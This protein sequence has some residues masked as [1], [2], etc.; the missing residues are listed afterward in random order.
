MGSTHEHLFTQMVILCQNYHTHTYYI[1]RAPEY[2]YKDYNIV[3]SFHGALN[4]DY[5]SD[6][7]VG[8]RRETASALGWKR[9]AVFIC[10][11][12]VSAGQRARAG[13]NDLLCWKSRPK[14]A[15]TQV[16]ISLDP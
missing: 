1:Y 3:S 10:S 11:W 5:T 4:T 16:Y 15:S 12:R 13:V 7:M 14:G 9:A 2:I 6:A 8:S